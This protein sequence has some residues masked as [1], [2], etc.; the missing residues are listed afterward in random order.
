MEIK[1][2]FWV[3]SAKRMADWETVKKECDR[4]SIFD[5]PGFIPMQ[6][7]A[8]KDGTGK[9]IYDGDICEVTNDE[10]ASHLQTVNCNYAKRLKKGDLLIIK[11]LLSGFTGQILTNQG[12]APNLIG[13]VCNYSLW[14]G[15]R[16]LKVIG[17]IY[18]NP[19]LI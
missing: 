13:N 8:L 14:N 15:A 10:N 7:I 11:K 6:Y 1:Y 19:E 16:Q 12:D 4:L 9:E 5:L 3:E 18:E 2:R 17:N